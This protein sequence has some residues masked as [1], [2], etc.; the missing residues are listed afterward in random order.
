MKSVNSILKC[1]PLIQICPCF[2]VMNGHTHTH[3]HIYMRLYVMQLS[4]MFALPLSVELAGSEQGVCVSD[5]NTTAYVVA[6]AAG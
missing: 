6:A 4:A 5:I 1:C 2:D 3:T